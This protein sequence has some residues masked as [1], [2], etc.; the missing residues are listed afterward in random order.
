MNEALQNL[1]D[2]HLPKAVSNLPVAPGWIIIYVLFMAL[3]GFSYLSYK[4]FKKRRA[5]NLALKKLKELEL[6]NE[7]NYKN[8]NVLAEI[9]TILRR[10]ALYYFKREDVA[11]ITGNSWIDFLNNKADKLIFTGKNANLLVQGP[12][13]NFREQDLNS[14]F[15]AVYEWL[16]IMS[17]KSQER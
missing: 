8:I 2:I 12:Y 1:A 6:L 11:S 15:A 14:L 9:S 7:E 16:R 13:R 17:A 5:V 3:I 4:Y 10:T